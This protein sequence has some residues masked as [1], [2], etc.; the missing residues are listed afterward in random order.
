MHTYLTIYL[1]GDVFVIHSVGLSL[2][3]LPKLDLKYEN[4]VSYLE[5]PASSRL[6]NLLY[7]A[8]LYI[9]KTQCRHTTRH[10]AN[11]QRGFKVSNTNS[12]AA[13]YT[14][15]KNDKLESPEGLHRTPCC[16]FEGNNNTPGIH[17]DDKDS[18]KRMTVTRCR[19]EGERG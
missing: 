5:W 3:A 10:N 11:A 17:P 6:H 18:H 8:M 4:A 9:S 19:R 14:I 1:N 2:P 16:S 15:T 13:D 12:L 7:K